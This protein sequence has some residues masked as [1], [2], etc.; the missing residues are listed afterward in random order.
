MF[1]LMAAIK[2]EYKTPHPAD[3]ADSAETA[4]P[5][6]FEPAENL[7]KV[8]DFSAGS[9]KS[10]NVRKNPQT[11]KSC[12]PL[13]KNE[14]TRKSANPQNPQPPVERI[15]QNPDAMLA[16]IAVMLQAD[17][18]QLRALLSDDDL[19]DIAQGFNSRSYMLDYFRLMRAGGKL[20]ACREPPAEFSKPPPSHT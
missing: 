4:Q 20:P 5:R 1:D 17:T 14:L 3:S 10:A 18:S 19:N 6:G 13:N 12:N 8:A 16:E 7:R 9:E 2:R 11:A 15:A